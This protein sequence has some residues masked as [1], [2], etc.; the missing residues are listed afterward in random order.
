VRM[1]KDHKTPNPEQPGRIFEAELHDGVGIDGNPPLSP[2]ERRRRVVQL[3]CSF[4]RNLAFHRAGLDIEVQRKL[5]D[6]RHPQAAFRREAHGNFF[7]VCVLDWCKLFADWKGEHHW[8]RVVDEHEHERFRADLHAT[9]G[10]TSDAFTKLITNIKGYRDQFVAHLDKKREM[11]LPALDT[12]KGAIVFLHEHLVQQ[13][14]CGDWSGLPTSPEQLE[15]GFAQAVREA[16]SVYADAL[17]R[18]AAM[19]R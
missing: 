19:E 14:G 2:D 4:M 15:Q 1:S 11:L 18:L 16:R 3:C 12:A 7:D 17:A 5:L 10:V 6:S 8:R 9:L 13:A